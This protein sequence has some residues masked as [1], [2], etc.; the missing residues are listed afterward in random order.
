MRA[1]PAGRLLP[2]GHCEPAWYHGH[3]SLRGRQG[4][5]A[6]VRRLLHG[7]WFVPPAPQQMQPQPASLRSHSH[8]RT[9]AAC[10]AGFSYRYE[11]KECPEGHLCPAGTSE[12][13]LRAERSKSCQELAISHL[14]DTGYAVPDDA[15][16]G[17]YCPP[18]SSPYEH[19]VNNPSLMMPACREGFYCPNSSLAVRCPAGSFCKAGVAEPTECTVRPCPPSFPCSFPLWTSAPARARGTC[20][21]HRRTERSRSPDPLPRSLPTYRACP[22]ASAAAQAPPTQ[23]LRSS[24][25]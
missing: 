15:P 7:D 9:V 5:H 2:R 16:T 14:N 13:L 10:G 19:L 18:G 1:L 12:V 25:L 3:G 8:V 24:T 11:V 6:A 21:C 4:V 22:T 23:I 17:G 20:A